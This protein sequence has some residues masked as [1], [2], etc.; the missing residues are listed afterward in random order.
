MAGE[1]RLLSAYCVGSALI[2][3]L[4]PHTVCKCPQF[5]SDL[6][7]SLPALGPHLAISV[8]LHLMRPYREREGKVLGGRVLSCSRF[9]S[10]A[11][12][13][14]RFQEPPLNGVLSN[15]LH[16]I[17]FNH[18]EALAGFKFLAHAHGRFKSQGHRRACK[19]KAPPPPPC[20]PSAPS[21]ATPSS[22]W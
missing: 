15:S 12:I 7:S 3:S 17:L 9:P 13:S 14:L 22:C 8:R 11:S 1:A 16:F 18:K 21:G 10:K 19:G 6:S 2:P 20:C 4:P 5:F